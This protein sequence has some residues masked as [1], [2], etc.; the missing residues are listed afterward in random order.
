[1]FYTAVLFLVQS[2]SPCNQHSGA[3]ATAGVGSTGWT[4]SNH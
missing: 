4:C 3:P 2:P 1:M